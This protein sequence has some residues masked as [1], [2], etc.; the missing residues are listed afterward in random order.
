[1]AEGLARRVGRVQLKKS[2]PK[3][4][5]IARREQVRPL[6]KSG[7]DRVRTCDFCHVKTALYR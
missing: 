3:P 4:E 1:M 6:R 5:S 2:E 7:R